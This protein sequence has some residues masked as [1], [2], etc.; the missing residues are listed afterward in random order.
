MIDLND[1]RA[2]QADGVVCLR[3]A[4]GPEWLDAA[5]RGIDSNLAH[6]GPF[7]RD[8]T[9]EGSPSRY[10]FDYWTWQD[11]PEFRDLVL[12]SPAGRIAGEIMQAKSVTMIMDNWFL[13]EAGATGSAPWHH[14]EPY[15]DFEGRMCNIWIPLEPVSR[16]EGL[17]FLVGSHRWD[18]VFAPF[19]FRTHEVFDGVG[20]AYPPI[21]DIENER[22]KHEFRSFALEPGDC[23]VFDLRTLHHA[24]AGRNALARTIRRYTLRFAA[25][26]TRFRPRGAW[27]QEITDYLISLGQEVGA[28]LDCPLLPEVWRRSPKSNITSVA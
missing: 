23:L 7:F 28:E 8:Q 25:E 2:Y 26:G 20:D 11:I 5:R 27:T 21:P 18:K 4:F 15:F 24:T 6:R 1:I 14:D 12:H 17:E 16:E 22:D 3:G 13:R 10:V 19:H 9:P